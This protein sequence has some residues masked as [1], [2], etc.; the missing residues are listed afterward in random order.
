MLKLSRFLKRS[1]LTILFAVLL[2][3]VKVGTDLSLPFFTSRIVNIGIQQSGIESF[4]PPS[5]SEQTF[6]MFLEK[7]EQSTTEALRTSYVY[8][9]QHHVF[10]L[11][12]NYTVDESMMLALISGQGGDLED[13]LEKQQAIGFLTQE[14]EAL[15]IN[16]A[17]TQMK[18]ISKMGLFMLLV[19][20]VGMVAS[21]FVSFFASRTCRGGIP[22]L[23]AHKGFRYGRS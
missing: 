22:P 6:T 11:Q 21:I 17:S 14:Y 5:L 12:S 10:H 13:N 9:E 15:G 20:L 8:D 4:I 18:Y 16:I 3:I 23:L 2:L 7:G 19:S 1:S